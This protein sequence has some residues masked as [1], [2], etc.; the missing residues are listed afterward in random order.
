MAQSVSSPRMESA[1]FHH[2]NLDRNWFGTE[3]KDLSGEVPRSARI[4]EPIGT[5]KNLFESPWLREP[6]ATWLKDTRNHMEQEW[7]GL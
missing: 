2:Y 7:S 3:L 5:L 1:S 6:A 4:V